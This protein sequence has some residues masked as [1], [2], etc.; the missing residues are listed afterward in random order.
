MSARKG[1][2]DEFAYNDEV[3]SRIKMYGALSSDLHTDMHECIG[4]ASDK[5]IRE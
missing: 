3:M 4:H 2:L 1:T 5:L